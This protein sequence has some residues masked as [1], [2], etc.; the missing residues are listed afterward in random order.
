MRKGIITLD[1]LIEFCKTHENFSFSSKENGHPL[2]LSTFGKAEYSPTNDEGLMSV[3]IKSCHTNLNRNN[4]FIKKDVMEKALPS[5]ANKPILAEL[6]TNSKGESDFGQHA[7]KVENDEDGNK[8]TIYIEKPVGIVPESCNA[9]FEYDKEKDKDYLVVDGYIFNYYGNETSEILQRRGSTDVS[10]ELDVY[11]V[12]WNAKEK[13]LEINDFIF[14]GVTLLGEDYSPGMEGAKLEI[15]DFSKYSSIDY[16]KEINEMKSR[17]AFLENRVSNKNL[18]EGGNTKIMS[19]F[20]ELLAKYN[21]TADDITF[22]YDDLSDEELEIKFAELFG[23]TDSDTSSEENQDDSE[24]SDKGDSKSDVKGSSF[25]D[26]NS[27]DNNSDDDNSDDDEESNSAWGTDETS[28]QKSDDEDT[29][30]TTKKKF[31]L[32]MQDT[33]TAISELVNATYSESDN[34]WYSVIVYN[35]YVVMRGW[36]TDR[37]YKQSYK[38][39]N[40]T[41]TL[42]GDRVEVFCQYLTQQEIDELEEL[43]KNYSSLAE[44]KDNYEKEKILAQKQ[45]LLNDECF[46]KIRDVESYKE[47][48]KDVDKYSFEEL[49]TKLKLIVADIALGNKDFSFYDKQKSGKMFTIP[50]KHKDS[51]ESKYGGIF[52]KN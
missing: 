37:S 18:K 19:K 14:C 26:D 36:W 32:S 12:S 13:Y 41:F 15:E 2:V 44:F 11:E 20:E 9:H 28:G 21:K 7:I 16:T 29:S 34:D 23:E 51:V 25:A 52:R 10:V 42:T 47:L 8:K 6:T 43:K 27:D 38:N 30:E 49:E 48:E 39:E 24:K 33:I 3:V 17:L 4:S 46:E 31:E 40:D 22:D 50:E 35:D 5:F 1:G 45:D